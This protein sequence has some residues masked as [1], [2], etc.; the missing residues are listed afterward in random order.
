MPSCS[1]QNVLG[2]QP[3]MPNVNKNEKR[4]IYVL[5]VVDVA[6]VIALAFLQGRPSADVAATVAALAAL[7]AVGVYVYAH[8]RTRR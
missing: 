6:A 7:S 5:A 2:S 3:T 1:S 8:L 4:L